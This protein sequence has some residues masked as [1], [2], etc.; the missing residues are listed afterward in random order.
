[1]YRRGHIKHTLRKLYPAAGA[2]VNDLIQQLQDE[3]IRIPGLQHFQLAHVQIPPGGV[4]LLV[5]PLDDGGDTV[6]LGLH[7]GLILE[8]QEKAVPDGVAGHTLA[9]LGDVVLDHLPAGLVFLMFSKALHPLYIVGG[10]CREGT[11]LQLDIIRG[12][13]QPGRVAGDDVLPV[14]GGFQVDVDG[15]DL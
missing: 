15:Q 6:P 5:Q 8:D 13:L 1:M 10:V 2:L 7:M 14:I 9:D 11:G 3:V 12:N 4:R